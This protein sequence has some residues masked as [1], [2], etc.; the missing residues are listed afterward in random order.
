MSQNPQYPQYPSIATSSQA[1]PRQG[2]ALNVTV[3]RT[4]GHPVRKQF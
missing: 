2:G 3:D 1:V 4:I